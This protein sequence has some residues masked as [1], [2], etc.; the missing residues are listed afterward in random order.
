MLWVYSLTA[1]EPYYLPLYSPPLL[2]RL[3]HRSTYVHC[4]LSHGTSECAKPKSRV[5][6]LGRDTPS[7]PRS[8]IK[9]AGFVRT[10]GFVRITV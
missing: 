5:L 1:G 9:S 3:L 4:A 7:R 10:T 8:R 6:E 2:T